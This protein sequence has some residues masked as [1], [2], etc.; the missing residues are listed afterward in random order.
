M[1]SPGTLVKV[2]GASTLPMARD[3]HHITGTVV[4]VPPTLEATIEA[5]SQEANKS[6]SIRSHTPRSE[7]I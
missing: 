2:T 5:N 7:Y 1:T 3:G 4:R 6:P